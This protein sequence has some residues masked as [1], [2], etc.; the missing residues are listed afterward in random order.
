MPSIDQVARA[1]HD[2]VT[3]TAYRLGR[4]T[5]V[6]Q[7]AAKRNRAG[8]TATRV[9]TSVANQ[10]APLDERIQTAATLDIVIRAAGITIMNA[11]ALLMAG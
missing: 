3:S 5:G 4:E 1:M 8:V 10:Q 11:T 9:C 7:R 2:I 6:V